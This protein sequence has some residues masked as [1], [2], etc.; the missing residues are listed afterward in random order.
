M[1][2]YAKSAIKAVELF[3]VQEITIEEAWYKAV[4]LYTESVH[5]IK[6]ACPKATFLGL[7]EEGLI[8]GVPKG[9]YTSSIHN[10]EYAIEA[11]ELIKH[12]G[13]IHKEVLWDMI[14]DTC[15]KRH[16]AQLDVVYGLVSSN[17]I[18]I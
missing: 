5:S 13:L 9:S 4:S 1:K 17:H 3:Q 15:G 10:K 14:T 8:E 12:M 11:V 6:K 18:R 2:L 7:C 16:N